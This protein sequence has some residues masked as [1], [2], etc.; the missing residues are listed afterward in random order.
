MTTRLRVLLL[1]CASASALVLAGN[2]LAAFAPSLGIRHQP[3]TTGA[4]SATTVRVAV[5]RDDD[6]LAR[7]SIYVPP[8]YTA[9][10]N[11][12]VGAQVGTASAQILVREP[13]AGAVLPVEGTM[14]VADPNALV[15]PTNTT[16][17]ATTVQRCTGTATHTAIWLASL[18]AAGQTLDV[19]IA[20]DAAA[21]PVSA[22][23]SYVLT[24]CLPSPN[25]PV[26]AGGA[27]FGAKLVLAQL[28]LAGI[29]TTPSSRGTYR[30]H[31]LATPWPA[32]GTTPNAAGTVEGQGTVQLPARINNLRAVSRRGR[33]AVRGTLVEGSQGVAQRQVRVRIGNRTF[34]ARTNAGGAFTVTAR[35]RVGQR[36]T[37]TA[38]ATVPERSI[39]CSSPSPFPGVTCVSETLQSFTATATIR[40][41]VR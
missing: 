10:L 32:S 28:N 36:L 39:P 7:G 30:W 22:L 8:G 12:A 35:R 23:A 38:T 34:L 2:A 33:L 17:I 41:R 6:A 25:I 16:S 14:T 29:F 15:R 9:T 21:A 40:H 26:T 27:P 1:A 20:V 19:P 18:Q 13:I 31:V 4:A 11:Q 3:A 37:I 5:P 24:F